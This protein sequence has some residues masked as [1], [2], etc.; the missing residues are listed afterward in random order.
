MHAIDWLFSVLAFLIFCCDCCG[1]VRTTRTR[2][3]WHKKSTKKR[4][5]RLRDDIEAN[6]DTQ[7]KN[8]FLIIWMPFLSILTTILIS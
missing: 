6:G 1:Y 5:S 2:A 8:A 4:E 7:T 3:S